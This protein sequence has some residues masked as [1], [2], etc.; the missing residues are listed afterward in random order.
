M[1]EL[2]VIGV[3]AG[4]MQ[5]LSKLLPAFPDDYKIPVAIVQ[6]IGAND[7]DYL[8]TYYSKICQLPVSW[9]RPAMPIAE[10]HIYFA[11]PG[12][13]LLVENDRTFNLSVD[14][15]VNH[16]RPPIDV[17]FD[18]AADVFHEKLVGVI[19]TGASIDGSEGLRNIKNHNGLTL[20]QDPDEAEVETMPQAAI[21]AA[22]VD[23]TFSLEELKLLL[24]R[25]PNE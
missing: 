2:I 15:R 20:V 16:S 18:S 14:D 1:Y 17:L 10:G 19:L 6:H 24:M 23:K 8:P 22:G 4:G 25:L 7:N 11:P 3:S 21:E 5:A 12:Y 9:A 13:H